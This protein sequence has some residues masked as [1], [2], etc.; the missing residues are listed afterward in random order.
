M[1]MFENLKQ[2]INYSDHNLY[3]GV[4]DF[5]DLVQFNMYE[6][7]YALLLC[8]K[9]P[10]YLEK[11]SKHDK[12]A[13]YATLI[14][15]YKRIIEREFKS[16]SGIEDISTEELEINDGI[17]QM[18]VTGKVTMQ[19]GSTF[20]MTYQEKSGSP[21][22]RLHELFLTGLRDPRAGQVKHYHGIIGHGSE[23]AIKPDEVGFDMETFTF[24]Y[25]VTDNTMLNIEKA[26]L[27]TAAQPTGA[28]TSIYNYERG[29]IEFKDID[30]EFRGFPLT[31]SKIDAKAKNYLEWIHANKL[32]TINSTDYNYKEISQSKDSDPLLTAT[33]YKPDVITGR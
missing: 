31:S 26:Y 27:I 9:I 18:T 20:S 15:N 24:L 25:I 17:N 5:T 22:T 16:L 3:S 6:G 28:N 8:I 32:Y 30:V 10:E 29:G 1:A 23:F 11:L 7:G 14:E 12:G 4:T 2:S 19:S 13:K 21:I 33:T